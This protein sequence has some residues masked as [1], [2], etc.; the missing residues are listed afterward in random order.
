MGKKKKLKAEVK[1]LGAELAE[2]RAH[3]EAECEYLERLVAHYRGL[4][5]K[6]RET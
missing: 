4:V 6:N 3:Y 5:E 1:R 2:M